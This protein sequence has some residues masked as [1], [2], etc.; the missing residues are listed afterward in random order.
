MLGKFFQVDGKQLQQQYKEHISDFSSWEQ[1]DHACDWMLFENN[2]GAHL[3][4]DETALSNG[5][6][7]TIV[8][9]KSARGRKGCIVAMIKGTQAEELIEVLNKIPERIRKRVTEVTM[10]MA[11]AMSLVIKRCFPHAS[12]V[13]DRFHVQKLAYDAV[14]EIRIKYRW[15]ALEQEN[16]QIAAAKRNKQVYE[17]ELLSN[18]DSIKQLLARSRYLLFKHPTKWTPSQKQRA[19]LLFERYPLIDQAYKLSIR[20]GF[21]FKNCTS[22]EQ[23]FKKLALWYNDIEDCGID[24]F[25]TVAR[26][27]QAHYTYILNFFNNRSTNASAES[28]NAKIK[29]FRASSRGVRDIQF[30]LYRLSKIYA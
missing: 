16:E 6:L 2:V 8:T 26:S 3:S 19:D 4:I 20:L 9:N 22:K 27:I 21:I 10:D 5:E 7:Y 23:A 13:I 14:Q 17:P 30:F 1:K 28:F 12:R 18:G 15:E 24:S 11:A 25:K 29:A